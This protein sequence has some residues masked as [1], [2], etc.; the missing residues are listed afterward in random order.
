MTR[1]QRGMGLAELLAALALGLLI[2][3]A[4]I[5]LLLAAISGYRL[6]EEAIRMEETGRYAIESIA[7][8]VRQAGYQDHAPGATAMPPQDAAIA[9]RDAASLGNGGGIETAASALVNGS[10]VLEL[11]FMG[12]AD[13]MLKNCGGFPVTGTVP[14]GRYAGQSIFFV[15]RGGAGEP[16]LRCRYAGENKS[17]ADALAPGIESFQVL[18]GLDADGDGLP[19]DFVTA[20][21]LDRLDRAAGTGIGSGSATGIE[22]ESETGAGTGTVTGQ[23]GP[24]PRTHWKQIVAVRL[25]LL[26]R[27]RHLHGD[28]VSPARLDLFGAEYAQAHAASDPGSSVSP[29]QFP[30][31]TRNRLRKV[32]TATVY[33]RNRPGA[34]AS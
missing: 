10:D 9:G 34:G 12:S 20:S 24:G 22:A 16:E 1:S 3:L 23:S 7:R 21:A 2:A 15:S 25:G 17:G 4:A 11:R 30:A 14:S 8:A 28:G 29:E 13:E 19:E 18:Y 32:F 6:Q 33:L 26:V 5:A 31:A 27:G